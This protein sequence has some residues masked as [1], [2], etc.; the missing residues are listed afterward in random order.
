MRSYGALPKHL[1]QEAKERVRMNY[2]PILLALLV[3][4]GIFAGLLCARSFT[5]QYSH[6][7]VCNLATAACIAFIMCLLFMWAE[8]RHKEQVLHILQPSWLFFI[9]TMS[10]VA[11]VLATFLGE[12]N[13]QVNTEPYYDINNLGTYA[14][15]DPNTARGQA[16]MDAG[17]VVFMQG[18]HLELEHAM[19]FKSSE[20]YC[21][22]PIARNTAHGN[23]TGL[24]VYDF[25]AVGTNCCD[26]SSGGDFRCGSF[27]DSRIHGGVRLLNEADQP[28]Y[29]LAVQQAEAAFKIKAV[30]PIFLYWIANPVEEVNSYMASGSSFYNNAIIIAGVVQATLVLLFL[31][32]ISKMKW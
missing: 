30:H 29:R 22:A 24:A 18:A 23:G 21:V 8:K 10:A 1:Q 13:Y 7:L 28:Y 26:G 15:V 32:G 6:P 3:P 4:W 12:Y 16:L 2:W 9:L 5:L 14:N 17:K 25:W 20:T 11:T 27:Y 19:G 31:L